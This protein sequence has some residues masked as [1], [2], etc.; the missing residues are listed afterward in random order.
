MHNLVNTWALEVNAL[1]VCIADLEE[2]ERIVAAA[3]GLDDELAT[4]GWEGL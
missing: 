3:L 4:R 2:G 1:V